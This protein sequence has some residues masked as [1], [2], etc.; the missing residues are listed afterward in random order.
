MIRVSKEEEEAR[1]VVTVEGQ[2]SADCIQLLETCCNQAMAAAKPVCLFLR[3]VP[4]VDRSG[5]ALLKRLAERGVAVTANGVYTSYIV[6]ALQL[7]A[8]GAPSS[9]PCK[10]SGDHPWICTYTIAP[11]RS[12]LCCAGR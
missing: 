11:R 8:A 12:V 7:G 1:T 10:R 3:D 9:A 4:I 6:Q 2:I 5:Y